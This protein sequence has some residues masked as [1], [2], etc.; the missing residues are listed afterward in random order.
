MPVDSDGYPY[1]PGAAEGLGIQ[2][3]RV[4]GSLGRRGF[5]V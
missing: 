5:G 2:R 1:R 4:W 3:F